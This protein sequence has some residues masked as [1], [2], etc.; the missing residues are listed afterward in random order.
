MSMEN[1]PNQG[2]KPVEHPGQGSRPGQ[3]VPQG[4]KE[5]TGSQE[6]GKTTP[7]KGVPASQDKGGR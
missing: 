1:K 5:T 2:N 4:G 7:E 3:G 6:T